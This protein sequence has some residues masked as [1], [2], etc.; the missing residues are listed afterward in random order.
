MFPTESS[1]SGGVE[2]HAP[3]G[4]VTQRRWV[5]EVGAGHHLL[6]EERAKVIQLRDVELLGGQNMDA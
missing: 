2:W 3:R 6:G 1:D 4:D 5:E